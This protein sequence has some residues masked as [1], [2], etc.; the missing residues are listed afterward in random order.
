VT[1]GPL[2][3]VDILSD[4]KLLDT[5]HYAYR[6]LGKM[7]HTDIAIHY[8]VWLAHIKIISQMKDQS[9]ASY[10]QVKFLTHCENMFDLDSLII[11]PI[12]A[13]YFVAQNP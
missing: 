12:M 11:D 10:E 9:L 7:Y 3:G 2:R 13:N 4:Q 5:S 8:Y 1:Q 6:E